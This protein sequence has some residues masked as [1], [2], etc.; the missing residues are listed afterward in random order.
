MTLPRIFRAK[1]L[2]SGPASSSNLVLARSSKGLAVLIFAALTLTLGACKKKEP[3]IIEPLRLAAS[4]KSRVTRSEAPRATRMRVEVLRTLPHDTDAFTQ[5]LFI[6]RGRLFES[7]GLVGKSS[8]REVDLDTGRVLRK[9]DIPAPHFGEGITLAGDSI[10]ML[11]WQTGAVF[12][13]ALEDFRLIETYKI[14]GEG[15]GIT[16]DGERL[17][18]SDGSAYL[19]FRD[20]KDFSSL[21]RKEIRLDGHPVDRINELEY[22]DGKVYANRWRTDDI[23]IIDPERGVVEALVD[24]SGLLTGVA[25]FRADVLNGIAYDE[26]GDRLFITGKLWPKLYEIR[27]VPRSLEPSKE[28]L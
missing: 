12:R 6:H 15:W 24:A 26:D 8:L 10:F 7:T 9:V 11:T 22:I 20:P 3:E 5:G 28:N 23:L 19:E 21:G 1:R 4:S 25:R 13:Y 2:V 16:F 27:I 18:M 17:I 14:E